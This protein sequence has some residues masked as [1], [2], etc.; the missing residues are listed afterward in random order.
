MYASTLRRWVS[1]F[2]QASGSGRHM[3]NAVP[4]AREAPTEISDTSVRKR[5][6][7]SANVTLR[8]RTFASLP[9]DSDHGVP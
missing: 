2:V 8:Q 4:T 6:S 3:K 7:N 1:A 9:G 5:D